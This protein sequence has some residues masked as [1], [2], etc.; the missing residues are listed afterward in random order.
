MDI[1]RPR[2]LTFPMA[3]GSGCGCG[4]PPPGEHEGPSQADLERFS[5]VT[6]PCPQCGAELYDDVELCWKCGHALQEAPGKAPW[7][8][9]AVAI[10]MVVGIVI[11]FLR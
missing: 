4:G 6:R 3:C 2:A 1:V 10:V 11:F 7:W 9:I 8:I 5:G